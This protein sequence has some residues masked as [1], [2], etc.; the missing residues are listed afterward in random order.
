MKHIVFLDRD[1]T[2]N[3]E[4]GLFYKKE[5]FELLPGAIE[6]IKLLNSNGFLVVVITNQPGVAKGMYSEKDVHALHHHMIDLLELGGAKLDAIY[7]CPHHPEKGHVG[8]DPRYK[9]E[10]ECRKPGISMLQDAAKKFHVDLKKCWM[11]GDRTV[12]VKAGHNAGC[13][14][15]VLKTGA[16]GKDGKFDVKA[17]F[18]CDTILD[19]VM[20]LIQQ[21]KEEKN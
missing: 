19:A 3:H 4:C 16:A 1:G 13:K 7:F 2:I 17:D 11:V 9:I 12:D 14:T 15:I 18:E 8:E 5:E 10:C 6:A 20:L 21:S